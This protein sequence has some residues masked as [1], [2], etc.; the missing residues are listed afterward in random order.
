M[1]DIESLQRHGME[2]ALVSGVRHFSLMEDADTFNRVL[3]ETIERFTDQAERLP[4]S[5]R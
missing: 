5:L 1:T 4:P 3:R 2:T